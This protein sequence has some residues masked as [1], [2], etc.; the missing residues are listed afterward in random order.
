MNGEALKKDG[1]LMLDYISN[2]WE[3][4]RDLAPLHNVEVGY[5]T[6]EGVLP[7]EAPDKPDTLEDILRDVDKHII[8]GNTQWQ[9]PN[10]HAYFASSC[11]YPSILADML[12]GA[13]ACIGFTWNS[14]PACS[15][16]EVVMLNWLG[17]LL[18]LPESFLNIPGQPGGGVLQS[19][20]SD[21]TLVALLA[22][23]T[24]KL[25]EVDPSKEFLGLIDK[26]VCYA[27]DQSHSSVERAAL[28]GHVQMRLLPPD[29]KYSLRGETLQKAIEKDK[30]EG[31]IPFYVAATVGTTGLCGF[32]NLV[33]LGNICNKERIWLHIDAAYAGSA[34]ICPEYRHIIDGVELAD[35][36]NF[37]PHKWMMVNFDCSAMWMKDYYMVADAFSVEPLYLQHKHDQSF[38]DFRHLQIPLGRRF[39]SL[40]LWFVFRL[41]GVEAL[42]QN[43]RNQIALAKEFEELVKGDRQYEII[44]EVTLGLV[45]FRLKASNELN[46][47]LN[48]YINDVDRRIHITPSKVNDT[49]YLRLAICSTKTTSEDIHLAWQVVQECAEIVRRKCP[50]LCNGA[51]K[52]DR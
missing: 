28:I 50:T 6:S 45:C 24:Q 52:C 9:H 12:C 36:F 25:K 47:T 23:R 16:L 22:A 48:D 44:G 39:K 51:S 5:L 38:V 10:F 27:S 8:P 20:A 49:Y 33:E 35:S 13:I 14:S 42:Q 7:S 26:L 18:K 32:D 1:H 21:A 41:L 34:A 3:N 15:E 29:D 19:T 40:K 37:N 46:I 4:L 17:K 11:S 43:I 31:L 2:Y 30:K